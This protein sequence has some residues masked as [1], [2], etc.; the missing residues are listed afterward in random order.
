MSHAVHGH[1]R[2]TG[3]SEE[4]WQNMVNW[5]RKWQPTLVFL[6]EEPYGQYEKAKRYDTR[7]WALLLG[8]KASN[9]LLGKWKWKLLSHVWLFATPWTMY[10]PQSSA[11][12]NTGVG[13]LSL[14]QRISQPR[15]GPQVS[16]IAGRFFT[17]WA[18]REVLRGAT[19]T[20]NQF[21]QMK[22]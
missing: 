19:S 3:H 14:L 8:Q 18:T 13:S 16:C 2:W 15:D 9:M 11:D 17:I 12:Q 20:S 1:L 6:P 4:F 22:V 21:D 5:R 10:S 7:R